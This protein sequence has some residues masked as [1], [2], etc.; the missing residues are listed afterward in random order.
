MMGMN[1]SY[2]VEASKETGKEVSN[3]DFEMGLGW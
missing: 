2:Y 3:K 1:W